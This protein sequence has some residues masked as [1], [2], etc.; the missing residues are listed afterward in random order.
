MQ[1]HVSVSKNL[2]LLR[3]VSLNPNSLYHCVF[4]AA[5]SFTLSEARKKDQNSE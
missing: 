3:Q 5:L 2:G 1:G 4:T